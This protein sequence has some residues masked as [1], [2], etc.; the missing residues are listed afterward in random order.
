MISLSGVCG[1]VYDVELGRLVVLERNGTIVCVQWKEYFSNVAI[2]ENLSPSS[3]SAWCANE[4]RFYLSG[5]LK[6]F[7]THLGLANLKG[8]AFEQSVWRAVMEIPYGEVQSYAQ[9]AQKIGNPK[10]YRAVGSAC[11]KNPILMIIPCHR[12]VRSDGSMGHYAGGID[13][14]AK[15]LELET[16]GLRA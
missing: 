9:I 11:R 16:Y 5:R 8:S 10:A 4:L 3:L 15:L 12:V 1:G 14:K 13:R 2:F 7:S 6:H